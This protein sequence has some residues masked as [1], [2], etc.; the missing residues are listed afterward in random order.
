MRAPG[1]E[2]LFEAHGGL[3]PP[4]VIGDTPAGTQRV[5]PIPEGGRFEG[6]RMSGRMLGGHDWQVT[7]ADGVVVIDALYLL[8]T[9]DGVRFQCRNRGV[10]R[11]P[12]EVMK[13]LASGEDVDPE[14]YYFRCVPEFSAPAGKYDF[15]NDNVFLSTGARHP[16]SITVSFYQVT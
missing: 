3:H 7:R 15:L 11:G 16:N 13:R 4:M 5:I 6:P 1:L 10:R 8:E 9:D 12:E 2:L 14:E